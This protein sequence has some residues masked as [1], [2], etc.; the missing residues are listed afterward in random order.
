MASNSDFVQYIV[1]QCSGA[2]E[3]AVKK[4]MGDYCI[5]CNGVLFGLICDNNLY[6]KMT[7]AGEAVLDEVVLR[8]PYPSARDHFYITNVDDR[9]YL[10]DIIRATLPELISSKSKAKRSAVNRQVPASLDDVIEDNI[11]CSQDLRAFFEQY[12]GKNFR[13]KVDFQSWLRE[14]AG[15]TFRDA[16]EA[17]RML[18]T[19]RQ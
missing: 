2:G 19:R 13:F 3:I 12:L 15:L 6:I 10:E 8:P 7:E 11:V 9:D 14:N 16:V 1:D 18:T 17:Y 4:M 5:Y